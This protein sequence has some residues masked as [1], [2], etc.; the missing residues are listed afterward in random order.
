V[1][2]NKTKHPVPA[3]IKEGLQMNNPER[4][5]KFTLSH[6]M[7]DQMLLGKI[8]KKD[9]KKLHIFMDF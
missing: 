8:C 9:F 7:N 1:V 5:I 6:M 4:G 3:Y 2:E